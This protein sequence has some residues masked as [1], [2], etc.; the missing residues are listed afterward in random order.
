[1]INPIY[2]SRSVNNLTIR[3]AAISAFSRSTSSLLFAI[4]CAIT[5]KG[6]PGNPFNS[7]ITS[8]LR[9]NRS[10]IMP[11]AGIPS[12]SASMASCRLH[13]EQDPQS[14]V[15]ARIASAPEILASISGGTGLVASG[16]LTLKNSRAPYSFLRISAM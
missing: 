3:A 8:A 6:Y 16:F 14:P 13:D 2:A 12:R 9:T 5:A 11:T 1:M 7:P 4:G 15:A 10:V